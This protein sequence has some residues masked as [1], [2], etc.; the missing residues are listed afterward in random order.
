MPVTTALIGN[1]LAVAALVAVVS[2]GASLTNLLNTPRLYGQNW[3][4]GLNNLT[5]KQVRSVIATLDPYPA[6]T[7]VTYGVSG[8]YLKVAGV[9]VQ[10][11][12]V[13]VAKGPMVFSLVA[14]YYPKGDGQ[15]ALGSST[16][17]Q[18]RAHLGSRVP[19]TIITKSGVA[20]TRTLEVVGVVCLPPT[21]SIGGLG[22]GVV[23]SLHAAEITAC[24][25]EKSQSTCLRSLT[26]TQLDHASWGM[27]I[28]IVPS[29]S[30]QALL[31]K[32][33]RQYAPYLSLASVP[34]NL[35]NFGQAIDFPALLGATLALFG[36][37]TLA[38]LLFVSV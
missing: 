29:T 20:R 32:L 1:V 35:V 11:L 6:V 16:L 36:A 5:I 33:Q 18:T 3:Q 13:D 30:G 8:K 14:G 23:T 34:T 12:L 10:S 9:A 28:G 7:K 15:I 24:P 31:A 22:D 17:S 27:A 26:T 4:L 21:F 19:V 2:F 37:A 38:H 25:S